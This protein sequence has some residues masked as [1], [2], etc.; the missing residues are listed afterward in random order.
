MYGTV[1]RVR[2]RPG[3]VER[4]KALS[5]QFMARNVPGHVMTLVYQMDDDPQ[6]VWLAVAFDSK[7]SYVANAES[8][9][10]NDWYEQMSRELEAA[11]EWHDGEIVD[12]LKGGA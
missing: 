4:L 7:A 5:Q 2:V 11:P 1:A 12:Y 3:G 10:Q 8:P 9:A 6:S